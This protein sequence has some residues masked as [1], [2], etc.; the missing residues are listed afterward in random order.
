ML[1]RGAIVA[2]ARRQ[3]E[4]G[5]FESL[6]L[7]AVGRELG[8]TAPALYDHVDSKAELLALVAGE[9]YQELVRSF[10]AVSTGDV[11]DRLRN[12]ALAY[13]AFAM[14]RPELFRLMFQ[15]RPA[16][17][18]IDVDNE[19]PAATEAFEANVADVAEAISAGELV[20]RDVIDVSMALWASVHGVATVSQMMPAGEARRLAAD[21]IDAMLTGLRP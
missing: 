21:V 20:D 5:G 12:R 14:A 6:S 19:L 16:E 15:Y 8:V 7:R 13:V 4:S 17:V 9:G 1:S 11:V 10:E 3:V 18:A 2:A